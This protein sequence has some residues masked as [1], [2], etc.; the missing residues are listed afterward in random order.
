[1]KIDVHVHTKKIKTGDAETRN[2]LPSKF[3]EIIRQTDVNILAITNHNHF[4]I[5]Q[6]KQ[7]EDLVKDVCQIWP[8]VE[9]DILE[10]GRRAHLLV[11]ANP[12]IVNEFNTKCQLILNGV[13]VNTFNISIADTV[14]TF[15]ELDCLYIAHYMNKTPNLSD[16]EIELLSNLVPNPKRIIKE[17]INAISAGIF[18]SHGHNSIYG[19]DVH[20]WND[21]EEISK[22]LP[23]LR[24]PVDSFEQF[25]FLLE[26]DEA[27]I[28]TVLSYKEKENITIAPFNAAENISL[29]IYN[30]INILFGSKGTGK[31]D[32]LKSLS[33]Y[34]N[35]LGHKTNVYISNNEHLDEVFD[36]R[37]HDFNINVSDFGIDECI[38]EIEFIKRIT[39][40]G[41]TSLGK[42]KQ[43]YSQE[44]TNSIAKK[45]KIKTINCIDEEQ[46]NRK[47]SEVKN[48]ISKIQDIKTYITTDSN[49]EELISSSLLSELIDLLE[50]ISKELLI[51]IE[52]RFEEAKCIKLINQIVN[53]F[54]TEVT[55]KTGIP[56]KPAYTGFTNYARKRLELEN[57]IN[58]IIISV[59]TQINPIDEFAGN[60]GEK[61][62]I[63]CRT[64]LKIQDGSFSDGAYSTVKNI[65]KTPQKEFAQKIQSISR[66]IYSTDLF[67]KI[68]ELG[69]IEDIE[70]ITSVSDLLR[71]NRHFILN[72]SKYNPSNG[73]SSMILL[74]KELT[75]DKEIYLIDEPEK[76]LGNDY[77]NDVIVP[78][79]KE[80]AILGKKIIIA[81]HDANIA[82]RTLPYNSIYRLHENGLYYTL[83]GNPFFN[84]LKCINGIKE[85]LDWKEISMKTLEGGKEAFGERGKIYG[86]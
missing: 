26:K 23:E 10:N 13:N 74:H 64:N 45:L 17:A 58:K 65:N 38:S 43:H 61:G 79:I 71:F 49:I 69:Q 67:E 29:D 37:G 48:V 57:A 46:P 40:V 25:C 32:I 73:E 21:Y 33:E 63:F 41:V 27:T 18:I 44:E 1:M 76:S 4:D 82:V 62:E 83:T 77:I 2:I 20:D 80:K 7:I 59:N 75:N 28:N 54:N 34:Y 9:L 11:I 6:F 72:G 84:K 47:V 50:R 78:I 70:Y 81:T 55:R 68:A 5:D 42:Y 52:D 3:N 24:L 15:K 22:T 53:I 51:K 35:N 16:E 8:G 85:D 39:E 14:N 60:L 56:Q 19:S 66:T 30:D 12:K 86:N 36:L 31:T